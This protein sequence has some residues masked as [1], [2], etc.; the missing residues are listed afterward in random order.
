LGLLD[1]THLKSPM[2][3][4]YS[5]PLKDLVRVVIAHLCFCELSSVPESTYDSIH[6]LL[7][8]L[9]PIDHNI[10]EKIFESSQEIDVESL[11]RYGSH[12][13]RIDRSLV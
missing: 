4:D 9:D 5:M 3:P 11:L 12:Y 6:E 8:N 10:L 13:L 7:S 2:F 1:I